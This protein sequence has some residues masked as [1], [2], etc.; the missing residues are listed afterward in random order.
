MNNHFASR[1]EPIIL[2]RRLSSNTDW[3]DGPQN[4][5]DR[6]QRFSSFGIFHLGWERWECTQMNTDDLLAYLVASGIVRQIS[7]PVKLRT[8]AIS[9]VKATTISC[10]AVCELRRNFESL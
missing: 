8:G 7:S 2:S 9:F 1:D 6:S 3:T 5:E 4:L 10:I